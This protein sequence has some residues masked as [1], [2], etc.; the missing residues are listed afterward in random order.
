MDDRSV[1]QGTTLLIEDIPVDITRKDIKNFHLAVSPPEGRAQMTVPQQASDDHIRLAVT[2][3]LEWIR[4]QQAVYESLPKK[5]TNK[6]VSGESH[7]FMGHPY[8]L[9]V[10]EERGKHSLCL[11]KGQLMKLTVS[12]KT[13]KA[14]R[15]KV[16]TDWYRDQ[17]KQ[18]IPDFIKK[19]QP[20]LGVKVKDWNI[21]K[22]KERWG[23]FNKKEKR[24][25]LNPELAKK[26]LQCL[27]YILVHEMVHFLEPE[28]SDHFN[29]LM[30]QFYPQW[31]KARDLLSQAPVGEGN[32]AY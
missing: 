30:D 14:N 19:W 5:K 20:V 16:L 11:E 18:Q 27:E 13:S 32:W 7:Y 29:E 17:L 28:E 25:S 4:Q 22:M 12:P 1:T 15:E 26:P 21:R 6:M 31:R 9:D 2:A 8:Q 3:R 24:L 10:I 23:S